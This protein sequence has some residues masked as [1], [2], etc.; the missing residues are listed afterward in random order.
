MY[1][2]VIGIILYEDTYSI[3]NKKYIIFTD[4]SIKII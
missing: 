2:Y 1:K 4:L 3:I